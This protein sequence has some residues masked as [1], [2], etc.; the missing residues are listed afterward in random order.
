MPSGKPT[1]RATRVEKNVSISVG[2]ARSTKDDVTDWLRKIESPRSPL[3]AFP[4]QVTYCSMMESLSPSSSRSS[5]RRSSEAS[6]PSRIPAGSP[7][8]SFNSRKTPVATN[9]ITGIVAMSRRRIYEAT[10]LPPTRSWRFVPCVSRIM[11]RNAGARVHGPARRLFHHRRV[12]L[13]EPDVPEEPVREV[14]EAL[15]LVAMRAENEVVADLDQRHLLP[16]CLGVGVDRRFQ[17]LVVGGR[18]HVADRLV[19]RLALP[20]PW[21]GRIVERLGCRVRV[22]AEAGEKD[23]VGL[24][25]RAVLR[26]GG[27]VRNDELDR[28]ADA[29][30]LVLV[31]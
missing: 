18:H 11:D 27:P 8:V 9:S 22:L 5:S 1:T 10:L 12:R 19:L 26:H 24:G 17:R 21:P 25:V 6:G 20:E 14:V 28:H 15:H 7:G 29:F 4:S 16:Q 3:T 2:S 23:L 30:V 31:E 13:L